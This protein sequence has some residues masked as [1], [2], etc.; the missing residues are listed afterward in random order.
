MNLS[1]LNHLINMSAITIF[2][3]VF[4]FVFVYFMM[5]SSNR[6]PNEKVLNSIFGDNSRMILIYIMLILIVILFLFLLFILCR[7]GIDLL[8]KYK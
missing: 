1:S 4:C 7:N 2:I 3:V 6:D 5:K 8:Y